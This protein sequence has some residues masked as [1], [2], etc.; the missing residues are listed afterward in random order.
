PS[1]EQEPPQVAV[2]EHECDDLK[3]CRGWSCRALG[4]FQGS[5]YVGRKTFPRI[6]RSSLQL[7][8][9]DFCGSMTRRCA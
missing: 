2:L 5:P 4:C 1:P 8:T 3:S 9:L 6:S 7:S